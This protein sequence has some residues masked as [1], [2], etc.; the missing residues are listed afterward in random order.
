MGGVTFRTLSKTEISVGIYLS[1][2]VII[3]WFKASL[4]DL[5]LG[6]KKGKKTS[7]GGLDE[8]N[9]KVQKWADNQLW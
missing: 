1:M 8:L 4:R 3:S 7:Q 2:Y 6:Q 5:F 9:L